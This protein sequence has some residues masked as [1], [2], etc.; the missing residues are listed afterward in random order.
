MG[1]GMG[2]RLSI[3][4]ERGIVREGLCS[5]FGS[6]PEIELAGEADDMAGLARLIENSPPQVLIVSELLAGSTA[7]EVAKL[8]LA[9]DANIRII[10]LSDE[11]EIHNIRQFLS[12]GGA[13]YITIANDFS[14]FMRAV[15]AVV[16]KRIYMSP[17]V[18]DA[19]VANYV[20]VPPSDQAIPTEKELS[21]REREVLQHVAEGKSTKDTAA[22]LQIST[23][24]VDMHRQRIM[25]K[26][27]IHSVAQLTKYAIRKGIAQLQ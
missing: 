17:D 15:R 25:N 3:A 14:E 22:A 13:G 4:Y 8:V 26:L 19:M 16:T 23:K 21:A 9:M 10:G 12:S 20:L 24:T 27:K 1:E 7:Q 6:Q 2:I 11:L 5:F 18:A